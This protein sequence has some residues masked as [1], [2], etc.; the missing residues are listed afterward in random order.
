MQMQGLLQDLRFAFRWLRQ[1]PGFALAAMLTL[2]LGIG[3]NTAIFTVVN[4]VLIRPLPYPQPERL[5][6]VWNKYPKMGLA[7]AALSGPDFVDRRDRNRVFERLGVFADAGLNLTGGGEPERLQ[8]IRVSEGFFPVLGVA[9][10]AG[11]F[12]LPEEDRPGGAAVAIVGAG[13]WKRRFGS[14]PGLVGRSITLNG[15]PHTV[16]GIMP[17]G[18]A[19]PTPRTEIWVP[20][21]LSKETTD[22]SQRGNEFLDGAI[23]RLK[24]GV[25]LAQAQS[26]MDRITESILSEAPQEARDYFA[27]AGWGAVVVPLKENMVGDAGRALWVL[28]GAVACVLLIACANVS[29]LMLARSATRQKEIAVRLALGAG[30]WRILRLLLSESLMLA[31]VGGGIGYLFAAW[32]VDLLM[33]IRPVNLPR[34][35][36]VSLDGRVLVFTA[37][38]SILAGLLSGLAP[39]LQISSAGTAESLK[40]GARAVAGGGLSRRL[41]QG[42]VV[43]Q[44][45]LAL[46]L[47]IAAGLML[48]SFDGLQRVDPGFDSKDLLTMHLSLPQ[49]KYPEPVQILA[50]FH[51]LMDRVERLPGVQRAALASL[52]PFAE[53]NWTASFFTADHPPRPGE[54]L[55]LA[56]IRSVSPGYFATLGIPL[57]RGR[58]FTRQDGADAP[59][60]VIVDA[61]TA[62]RLWPGED[63][64]EKRITFSDTYEN[65]RWLTV[66]GVVGDVKDASL[67][68]EPRMMVYL[69][70]ERQADRAL[71]LAVRGRGAETGLLP[72]VRREIAALDPDLPIFAPRTERSYLEDALAQPRFRSRLV[73]LF[74]AVALLLASLGI[75]AV[76]A[77]AVAQRTREIGIRMSL[78]ARAADVEW[79]VLRQGIVSVAAGIS[80]GILAALAVTRVLAGLLF[81]V[82]A[83]DPLTFAGVSLLLAAV[84]LLASY[85]PAR[86]AAKVDPWTALRYE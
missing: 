8:G 56:S 61:S 76:I 71:F 3:A 84:A 66:V 73:G 49:S 34:L 9:P 78:G 48:R 23:A 83:R 24:P 82:G 16:V 10:G 55:P 26:D 43:S 72:L 86:R 77:N 39:A 47:L 13:L 54:T 41:R 4:A 85:V 68:Q 51:G 44:V 30:R 17:E 2:G 50:F 75:Y 36:E 11:R 5:V 35:E 60:A 12:F 59:R 64:L 38:V 42:L 70:Q 7:R 79:L 28:L 1:R 69:S 57:Q 22:V 46:V 45:A 18:F 27:G 62:R 19:F 65:A 15:K 52:V 37:A 74:A 21:A 29:N 63:P 67:D 31:L 6:M 25:P 20:L 81:G 40:E 53:G 80:I 33:A 32:G 58:D 14:D